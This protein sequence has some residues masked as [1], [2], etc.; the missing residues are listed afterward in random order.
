MKKLTVLFM[1]L[2][3][4]TSS[5]A[6]AST[7]PSIGLLPG[8]RFYSVKLFVENFRLMLTRTDEARA[9]LLSKQ[10]ELR[11]LEIASLQAEIVSEQVLGGALVRQEQT[12]DR[13]HTLL[14]AGKISD[15][16]AEKI[17]STQAK[18]METLLAN[19][20]KIPEKA[21]EALTQNIMR[22]GE[23][24]LAFA[25][26]KGE[27][28]GNEVKERLATAVMSALE[29]LP[30]QTAKALQARERVVAKLEE[31]L[32]NNKNKTV[33]VVR[34]GWSQM[35]QKLEQITTKSKGK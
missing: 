35:Q 16:T 21:Q 28:I 34:Q 10:A 12:L 30:A 3:L 8:H 13:L 32:A 17:L 9:E 7:E 29:T 4:V 24:I 31:H 19:L 14:E 20:E 5:V 15:E 25:E 6:A 27:K 26:K 22:R 11:A 33:D 2:M 1:M 18:V 23:K